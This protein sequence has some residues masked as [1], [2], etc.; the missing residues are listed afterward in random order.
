MPSLPGSRQ[1]RV[2]KVSLTS[3][4]FT[5]CCV[6]KSMLAVWLT[7]GMLRFPMPGQQWHLMTG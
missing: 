2:R 7:A 4:R 1:R 6:T 5:P 3:A